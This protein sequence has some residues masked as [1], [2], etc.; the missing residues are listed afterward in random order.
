MKKGKHSGRSWRHLPLRWKNTI[1]F[2]CLSILVAAVT[3]FLPIII[4]FMPRSWYEP[5]LLTQQ[6]QAAQKIETKQTVEKIQDEQEERDASKYKHQLRQEAHLIWGLDAPVS[7][8]A[9][10]IHQESLWDETA[11][12]PVGAIGLSQFMPATAN[13]IS[14]LHQDLKHNQPTNPVWAMRALVRYDKFLYERVKAINQCE[15]MAFALAA[16]NGGLGWVNK[17][18]E[19]SK[20]PLLCFDKTC[21]I[22]PGITRSNQN[23]NAEYP[24]RILL[25]YEASYIKD[26]WGPGSCQRSS[27]LLL[28]SSSS[29]KQSYH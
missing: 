11:K 3:F 2:F 6:E 5:A 29:N 9:A 18:K 13:W 20:Q 14:G 8:F 10:Q 1:K 24:R 26:G 23:E 21:A 17:R 25:K 12:S 7:T 28:S 22:N 19:K 16:Y 15:R 27:P 4:P